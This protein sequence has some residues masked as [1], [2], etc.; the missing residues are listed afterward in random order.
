MPGEKSVPE[1]L[2]EFLTRGIYCLKC[3]SENVETETE[4]DWNER[5]RLFIRG[6]EC[7]NCDY[8]FSI[9]YDMELAGIDYDHIIDEDVKEIIRQNFKEYEARYEIGTD[10]Y[11]MSCKS[12]RHL[13]VVDW[14]WNYYKDTGDGYICLKCT[15]CDFE[16]CFA[17]NLKISGIDTG[18]RHPGRSKESS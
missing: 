17:Y 12:S 13:E 6:V 3:G 18:L 10:H 14:K 1:I 16:T 11:C 5:Q 2:E 7:N 4:W 15:G 9:L 8:G